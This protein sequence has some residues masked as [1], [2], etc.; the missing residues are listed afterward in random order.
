MRHMYSIRHRVQSARTASEQVSSTNAFPSFA[1]S[2]FCCDTIG[3][4]Y[5]AGESKQQTG[6]FFCW[7]WLGWAGLGSTDNLNRKGKTPNWPISE[8]RPRST[9]ERPIRMFHPVSISG[10]QRRAWRQQYGVP[11]APNFASQHTVESSIQKSCGTFVQSLQNHK[12]MHSMLRLSETWHHP[13]RSSLL[14]SVPEGG[15]SSVRGWMD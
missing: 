8:P 6:A 7:A 12:C 1:V 11:R 2:L 3:E 13:N 9:V 5:A 15:V 10:R 4:D 14:W